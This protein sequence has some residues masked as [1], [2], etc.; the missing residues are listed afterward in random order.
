LNSILITGG[1][2]FIGSHTALRFANLGF[3]VTAVDN[4][5]PYYSVNLKKSRVQNLLKHENIRFVEGS[6]ADEDFSA[7]LISRV[8]PTSVIHLA[9]QPGVRLPI[10]EHYR[11]V[12]SNLQAFSNVIL[13]CAKQGVPKFLYASSSSVYGNSE[14]VPF[15][16]TD[17][18]IKPISF[19]GATKL[20]NEI[21]ASSASTNF[22][23]ASR[24]LRFFT[25]YGPWGRPDMAYFK[26]ATSLMDQKVFSLY[27]DGKIRRD[28][29]FVDDVVESIVKLTFQLE[30][31]TGF[32]DVVNVGGSQ[33][34][35]ML[36]LIEAVEDSFGSKVNVSF[37]DVFSADV[38]ETW[39]DTTYLES[40][41]EFKP[42][43]DL[44]SGIETFAQW[45]NS[46]EIQ[47]KRHDW[48]I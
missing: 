33:R 8:N 42:K 46:S 41:I 12:D 7:E 15:S 18:N 47:S 2:G 13:E 22:G 23:L 48:N 37:E 14:N 21:L 6:L 34:Y 19:Y 3:E 30:E 24:G 10:S 36:E 26:L 4:L 43:T 45:F 11:Y 44:R 25:V 28:F 9:A 39:A 20:S 1:A 29:T 38:N 32:A 35:S 5:S 31:N 17:R 27:G 16:E 40:L